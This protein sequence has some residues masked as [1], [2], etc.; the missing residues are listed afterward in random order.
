[1]LISGCTGPLK[2]IDE[3][4]PISPPANV[5][6]QTPVATVASTTEPTVM[7]TPPPKYE[8]RNI[9]KYKTI[10]EPVEIT[11]RTY[12]KQEI[13]KYR[14]DYAG[15]NY[16]YEPVKINL[17]RGYYHSWDGQG[18]GGERT[19]RVQYICS[20]KILNETWEQHNPNEYLLELNNLNFPPEEY[21]NC[22]PFI[23]TPEQIHR[24]D[25][26]NFTLYEITYNRT[27]ITD[28]YKDV[29]YTDFID[30]PIEYNETIMVPKNVTYNETILVPIN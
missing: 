27:I 21:K 24:V 16:T 8:Y 7:L 29:P 3:I 12:Q 13:T 14:K 11:K 9:T 18:Y 28:V 15:Q 4:A 25:G 19:Q 6:V 10:Y 22:D 20:Y 23:N 30:V 26:W 5:S 2:L 1:M 17:Y